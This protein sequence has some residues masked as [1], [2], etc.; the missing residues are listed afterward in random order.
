MTR[1]CPPS[2]SLAASMR[3]GGGRGS[4]TV[5][6]P[7]EVA[8]AEPVHGVLT[9]EHRPEEGDIAWAERVEAGMGP[10]FGGSGPAQGVEGG[11]AIALEGRSS[12]GVEVAAVRAVP[13]S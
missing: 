13:T 11:D 8:V 9:G 7:G 2:L 12:Q 5:E 1:P 3:L 4:L 6:L 10:P